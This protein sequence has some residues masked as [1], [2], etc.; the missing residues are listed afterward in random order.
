MK[1]FCIHLNI[2][3]SAYRH[4]L[5]ALSLFNSFV[6]LSLSHSFDLSP[7][8]SLR[9]KRIHKEAAIQTEKIVAKQWL[10]HLSFGMIELTFTVHHAHLPLSGVGVTE[11]FL[12]CT[13]RSQFFWPAKLAVTVELT[14]AEVASI[15]AAANTY[16]MAV[17][18]ARPIMPL[19]RIF[20]I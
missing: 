16:E 4:L 6:L 1:Y 7:Y 2:C 11:H 5:I 3:H 17:S 18:V 19:T 10:Q 12:A 9:T 15:L 8:L 20:N 13:G 14:K